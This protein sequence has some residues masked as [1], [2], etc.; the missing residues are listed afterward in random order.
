MSHRKKIK[1]NGEIN[2]HTQ[3]LIPINKYFQL[4]FKTQ[5]KSKQY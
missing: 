5:L 4:K 2:T 1:K 3:T